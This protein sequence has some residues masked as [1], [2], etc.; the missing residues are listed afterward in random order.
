MTFDCRRRTVQTQNHDGRHQ[1]PEVA[2]FSQEGIAEPLGD[3]QR[4]F[5]RK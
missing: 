2:V 4:A 3:M 5:R 1:G